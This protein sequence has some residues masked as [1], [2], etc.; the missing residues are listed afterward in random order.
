MRA[1]TAGASCV[2]PLSSLHEQGYALMS[3]TRLAAK[4][5]QSEEY[6]GIVFDGVILSIRVGYLAY[7]PYAHDAVVHLLGT[8]THPT[9][10][11]AQ[12][13]PQRLR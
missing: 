4:V 1:A 13:S 6:N 9:L 5:H 3:E 2:I 10:T 11:R 7:R 8:T 12:V